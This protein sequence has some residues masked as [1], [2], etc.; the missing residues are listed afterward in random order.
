MAT[1]PIVERAVEAL[2][3]RFEQGGYNPTPIIDLGVLVASADGSVD[4]EETE[5]LRRIVEPLLRARFS[6]E[7]L[8]YLIDASLQV[9]RAAGVEPR[10][11]LIA[12]ILMDCD[13]VEEG[14]IVALSVAHAS[15]GMSDPERKL[16]GALARA[17]RL[18]EGRL[19][20]LIQE[21]GRAADG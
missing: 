21:V 10:L 1:P 8:G 7:I 16:I 6:T 19:A 9:I 15:E 3:E 17:A 14:I 4:A 2:F 20:G 13:A 12:E 11:S 18:P 5:A